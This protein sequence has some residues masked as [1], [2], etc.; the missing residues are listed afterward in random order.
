MNKPFNINLSEN[1][2]PVRTKTGNNRLT[3][4]DLF[5]TASSLGTR[6]A[7]SMVSLPQSASDMVARADFSQL[8]ANL[9]TDDETVGMEPA[10]T[11]ETLPAVLTDKLAAAGTQMPEWHRVNNLPGNMSRAIRALGK[12]LFAEFTRTPTD[13]IVMIGNLAGQGP[14]TS[15]EVNSVAGWLRNNATDLGVGDINFENI[16][17]GYVADINQYST[18]DVRWLLVRD[19][20][21]SYIYTWPEEDSVLSVQKNNDNEQLPNKNTSTK[22]LTEVSGILSSPAAQLL[23]STPGGIDVVRYMHKKH[24]SHEVGIVS[25]TA[26]I[27]FKSK[28]DYEKVSL[29][30]DDYPWKTRT[31]A[32]YLFFVGAKG[33]AAVV[34][35]RHSG[36]QSQVEVVMGQG[37]LNEQEVKN[38]KD[39]QELT[40]LKR[41]QGS[42]L[43]PLGSLVYIESSRSDAIRD[44]FRVY[45]GPIKEVY[46]AHTTYSPYWDNTSEIPKDYSAAE[47]KEKRQR[48]K[49]EIEKSKSF[50]EFF[51]PKFKTILK[52]LVQQAIAELKG[53]IN[54]QIKNGAVTHIDRQVKHLKRLIDLY[55]VENW[56]TDVISNFL[57]TAISNAIQNAT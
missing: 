37:D 33:V 46:I 56:E 52:K 45:I 28:K 19:E 5:K 42:E 18:G 54:M 41:L 44:A 29:Y 11:P 35:A 13:K 6:A 25:I 30:K 43:R 9:D 50:K 10:V 22:Q 38:S 49:A 14:N 8:P 48:L 26:N 53:I 23:R 39:Y 20:Y 40:N 34:V 32:K 17:P 55:N 12:M 36:K 7:T 31:G 16:F 24:L 3:T 4:H 15:L 51:K 1:D 2:R 57:G 21:G 27:D 47:K